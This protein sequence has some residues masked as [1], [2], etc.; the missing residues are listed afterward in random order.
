MPE[1]VPKENVAEVMV[2]LEV[3]PGPVITNVAEPLRNGLC[4]LLPAMLPL[5]FE[6]MLPGPGGP[7]MRCVGAVEVPS[8]S[9]VAVVPLGVKPHPVPTVEPSVKLPPLLTVIS[10]P[11]ELLKL[12]P[13]R[14]P[15]PPR[16]KD[17]S[18][19]S[20]PTLVGFACRSVSVTSIIPLLIENPA[21][22]STGWPPSED[23]AGVL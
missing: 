8:T 2:V 9:K 11:E 14:L 19:R 16:V 7:I 10:C 3:M 5:A 12:A 17:R 15:P 1:V 4:G 18:L 23:P 21:V 13:V 22:A 20:C 6:Y